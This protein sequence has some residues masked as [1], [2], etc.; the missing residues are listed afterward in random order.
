[1][2][3]NG[4]GVPTFF[5]EIEN[6][7]GSV[8]GLA[9]GEERNPA[10]FFAIDE[11]QAMAGGKANGTVQDRV[12]EEAIGGDGGRGRHEG[13]GFLRHGPEAGLY[14]EEGGTARK[15]DKQVR[16]D[17]RE[18]PHFADFVRNDG[19]LGG[20]RDDGA[21]LFALEFLR[22]GELPAEKFNKTARARAAV[23]AEQ[24]HAEEENQQLKNLGVFERAEG[25]RRTVLLGFGEERRERVIEFALQ[26]CRGRLLVDDAGSE[27][28]VGFGEGLQGGENIGIGG[29]RLR[30]A[31][32][33]D[34]ES[35]GREKAAM[36]MDGVGSDANV[37]QGSVWSESTGVFVLVAV[38]GEKITAVGGAVDGDFA[39]RTTTNGANFFGFGGAKPARLT[40][41]ANWTSHERSPGTGKLET[42]HSELKLRRPG[43]IQTD[44]KIGHYPQEGSI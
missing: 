3:G 27:S 36:G 2:D 13:F 22:A 19:M 10:E 23:G 32:F 6:D 30:G 14:K 43:L 40:L 15:G 26:V 37:E 11:K 8:A 20:L 1:M 9:N 34:G 42:F 5:A 21:G 35:D 12:V 38:S 16:G 4:N 25:S 29:G 31:E 28:F 24:T 33:G 17:R 18:I 44:L 39:L 7:L 41:L